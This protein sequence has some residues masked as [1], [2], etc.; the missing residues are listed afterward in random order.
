MILGVVNSWQLCKGAKFDEVKTLLNALNS[1]F[2]KQKSQ[3]RIICVDNCCQWRDLLQN[4][5]GDILVKLDVF[6]SIKR[7]V[8]TTPVVENRAT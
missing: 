1:R 5:F 3:P 8:S 4:I 7:I 2:I 6:H